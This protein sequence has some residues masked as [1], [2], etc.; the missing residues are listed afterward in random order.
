M[1]LRARDHVL[2]LTAVLSVVS[3][4]AVFAAVGGVV[5]ASLLPVVPDSVVDA[6]PHVNAVLSTTGLVTIALGVRFIRRDD[7]RRHRAMMLTTFAL[8]VAFLVLYL[9]R[10]SLEGPAEFLGPDAVYQ[11][12]Y[13]PTLAVHVLLAI[14]CIP[15]LFYV[16]LLALSRPVAELYETPHRRVGRVAAALWF[17]SF[18]LGDVVYVLLY[19]VY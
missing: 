16:L 9:Y 8:F 15:L 6:I 4:A 10:I 11:F 7:V 18:A 2:E 19:V 14:V 5:P 12:V 1:E 13:L 3:L 17:V